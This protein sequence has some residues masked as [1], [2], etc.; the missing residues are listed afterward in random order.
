MSK[1]TRI[2]LL[3]LCTQTLAFSVAAQEKFDVVSFK[4]PAGW[5]KSVEQGA[6]QFT[7]REGNGEAIL[8]LFKSL[9]TNKDPRATFDASWESIVVGLFDKAGT[10]QMQ[11]SGNQNGW[12]IE[13]GAAIVEKS[14]T[15]AVANL[16]SATVGGKVVNLLVIT[17]SESFQSD[18]DA[19]IS[20]INLPA[21]KKTDVPSRP[22]SS[23]TVSQNKNA[24]ATS[25]SLNARYSCLKLAYRNGSSVYDPAGLGFTVSGSSYSVVGGTGGK[26][27]KGNDFVEFSGGRL[28]GY[29]GEIRDNNG[30]LYIFFRVKFTEI[31]RN[32][33]IRVGDMQCYRQ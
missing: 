23:A 25:A 24:A 28:N 30:K 2:F 14:G 1:L 4:A 33:S 7:K 19:F 11:P 21:V 6:V 27:L 22:T 10:P 31:R 12:T 5:Q 3:M 32:E 26:V 16:M 9:P 18:I 29:R 17:N 8:M 15:K 20:S 13:N